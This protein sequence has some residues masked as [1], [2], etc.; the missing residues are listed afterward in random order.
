MSVIRSMPPNDKYRSGWDRIFGQKQ[1]G[2][3]E[4]SYDYMGTVYVVKHP[5]SALFAYETRQEAEEY[6]AKLR[7]NQ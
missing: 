5:K 7:G 4:V 3:I 2:T 6:L 1:I